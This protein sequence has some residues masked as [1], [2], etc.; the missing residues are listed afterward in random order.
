MILMNNISFYLS[1]KGQ[2]RNITDN[3]KNLNYNIQPIYQQLKSMTQQSEIYQLILLCIIVTNIGYSIIFPIIPMVAD[4]KNL[5]KY[6]IGIIF[7]MYPLGNVV[8]SSIMANRELKKSTITN[9]LAICSLSYV[10]L[11][12]ANY[13]NGPLYLIFTATIR[14]INGIAANMVQVPSYALVPKLFPENS[15]QYI[16]TLEMVSGLATVIGPLIGA[17]ISIISDQMGIS[18]SLI[19]FLFMAL[20][21]M[22]IAVIIDKKMDQNLVESEKKQEYQFKIQDLQENKQLLLL[23]FNY[24]LQVIVVMGS[25]TQLSVEL[26]HTYH[27]PHYQVQLMFVTSTF[28]FCITALKISRTQLN[29]QQQIFNIGLIF[30]AISQFFYAPQVLGLPESP[31][32]ICFADLFRGSGFGIGCVLMMPLAIMILNDSE[33]FKET[34]NLIGSA[35]YLGC[36]S[37]GDFLGPLIFGVLNDLLGFQRSCFL[38]ASIQIIFVLVYIKNQQKTIQNPNVYIEMTEK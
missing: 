9:G 34:S 13:L 20:V 10:V 11:A 22:P 30:G 16:A 1:L 31:F 35:L 23:S 3:W 24:C 12:L 25:R 28:V 19:T 18:S 33:K 2:T 26:N 29:N 4:E 38:L 6:Q 32:I 8:S 27:L 14:F 5:Y 15:Q 36:W 7:A 17:T 37:F 21:H